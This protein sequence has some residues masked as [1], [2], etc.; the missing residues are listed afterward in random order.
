LQK[1]VRYDFPISERAAK[2]KPN[3]PSVAR[4]AMFSTS[5]TALRASV[6]CDLGHISVMTPLAAGADPDPNGRMKAAE[7]GQYIKKP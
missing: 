5:V 4:R 3:K 2:T 1:K 7:A 6:L